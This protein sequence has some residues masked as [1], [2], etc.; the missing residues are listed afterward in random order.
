MY[1]H[2]NTNT[3]TLHASTLL[4]SL[5]VVLLHHETPFEHP[6]QTNT[7]TSGKLLRGSSVLGLIL[8]TQRKGLT[9]QKTDTLV[10]HN[11]V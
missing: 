4:V 7:P 1:Q 6:Q 8:Q 5:H 9:A 11:L 10:E 3:T 2:T